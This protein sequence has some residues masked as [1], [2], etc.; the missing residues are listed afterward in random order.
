M[1]L[2]RLRRG[3]VGHGTVV[4]LVRLCASLGEVMLLVRCANVDD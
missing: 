3:V 4:V 2:V 1:L